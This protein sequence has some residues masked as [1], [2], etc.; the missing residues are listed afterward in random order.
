MLR[1]CGSCVDVHVFAYILLSVLVPVA[2]VIA[3]IDIERC[4]PQQLRLLSIHRPAHESAT[5]ETEAA[6]ML[7]SAEYMLV[8][9]CSMWI[10]DLMFVEGL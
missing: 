7:D 4:C 2:D 10:C 9:S 1:A 5:L 3:V 8:L 6:L